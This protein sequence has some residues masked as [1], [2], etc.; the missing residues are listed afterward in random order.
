MQIY[1]RIFIPMLLQLLAMLAVF[2]FMAKW[3]EILLPVICLM[4]NE[5][6]TLPVGMLCWPGGLWFG[7]DPQMLAAA[8]LGL[9]PILSVFLFAERYF[10]Q[11]HSASGLSDSELYLHP[12]AKHVRCL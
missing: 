10:V 11:N 3:N 12:L 6:Y 1:V 4:S 5:N 8:L 2:T 9:I 7:N